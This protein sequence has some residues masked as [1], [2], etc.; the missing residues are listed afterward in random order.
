MRGDR[1]EIGLFIIVQEK[2]IL[3]QNI[4]GIKIS[5]PFY[6]WKQDLQTTQRFVQVMPV[7]QTAF[8]EKKNISELSN[9]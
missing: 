5:F 6:M 2:K 1:T 7:I 8:F 9:F 3:K 4:F